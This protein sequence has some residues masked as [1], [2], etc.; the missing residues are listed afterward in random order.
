MNS[1]QMKAKVASHS[2]RGIA[3]EPGEVIRTDRN[4]MALHPHKFVEVGNMPDSHWPEDIPWSDD[5]A[6][7]CYVVP[8]EADTFR[9][10]KGTECIR[11]GLTADKAWQICRNTNNGFKSPTTAPK[12]AETQPVEETAEERKARKL[13]ARKRRQEEDED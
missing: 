2:E 1:Y 3:Y 12:S 10:M 5:D 7:T 9:V 11:R 13:A 6:G 4:L 8:G